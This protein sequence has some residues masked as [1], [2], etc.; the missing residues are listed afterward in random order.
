MTRVEQRRKWDREFRARRKAAGLC[1]FCPNLSP[2]FVA[3]FTCRRRM[4]EWERTRRVRAR[5][6]R[7][8]A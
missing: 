6:S 7:S 8:D 3:C 5:K 4:N 1:I 2:R